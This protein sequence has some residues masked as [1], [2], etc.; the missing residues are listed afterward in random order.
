MTPHNATATALL[1]AA[2][3]TRGL[4]YAKCAGV[5]SK[6]KETLYMVKTSKMLINCTSAGNQTNSFSGC[7]TVFFPLHT[8]NVFLPLGTIVN[9]DFQTTKANTHYSNPIPLAQPI[10]KEMRAPHLVFADLK[11]FLHF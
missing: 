9:T 11:I 4:R 1:A 8:Q 5:K 7:S 6:A 2:H 3:T 10:L